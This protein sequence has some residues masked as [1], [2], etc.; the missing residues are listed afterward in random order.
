MAS[1]ESW[2]FKSVNSLLREL[3]PREGE[4]KVYEKFK[5]LLQQA[6]QYSA[7]E[8]PDEWRPPGN[9]YYQEGLKNLAAESLATTLELRKN[10]PL[11]LPFDRQEETHKKLI[12]AAL[13][14][15][16]YM[17]LQ[18]EQCRIDK[19][20]GA[21]QERAGNIVKDLTTWADAVSAPDCSRNSTKDQQDPQ[22]GNYNWEPEQ[23]IQAYHV[24]VTSPRAVALVEE[25]SPGN[26]LLLLP[27]TEGWEA[28]MSVIRERI[29]EDYPS[30]LEQPWRKAVA[31]RMD[32]RTRISQR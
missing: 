31:R 2:G 21:M 12:T 5:K 16:N 3:G 10:R 13:K 28:A 32:V 22:W 17:N 8:P 27:S 26:D 18:G 19:A 7:G 25:N 29:I 15:G 30:M 1:S 24:G 23:S 20:N 4:R 14:M 11:Q 6:T 9:G